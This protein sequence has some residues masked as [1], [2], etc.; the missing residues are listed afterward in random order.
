MVLKQ[1]FTLEE[2]AEGGPAFATELEADVL[3]E[4]TK[5]GVVEKARALIGL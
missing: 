1:M 3:A 5:L 2:A 4:A